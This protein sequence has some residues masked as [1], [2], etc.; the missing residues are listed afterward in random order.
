MG[1]ARDPKTQIGV[2]FDPDRSYDEKKELWS[3]W[4]DFVRNE[5]EP[6]RIPKFAKLERPPV[7]II[8]A[9]KAIWD[10]NRDILHHPDKIYP[11]QELKIP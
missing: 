9:W 2:D 1:D 6:D 5:W 8:P 3:L 7:R 10:A 4:W 11:G